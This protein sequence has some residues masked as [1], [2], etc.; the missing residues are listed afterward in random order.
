[1]KNDYIDTVGHDILSWTVRH[2]R[3]AGLEVDEQSATP[4]SASDRVAPR[5]T[6]NPIQRRRWLRE[7]VLNRSPL[8]TRAFAY[9]FYRYVIR[10]GFLDGK[11]G[12][13]FHFLQ[14][15]WYR[16][17]IDAVVYERSLARGAAPR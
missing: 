8:F 12:L 13:I 16:F 9:W 17:L 1:L 5:L 14:G 4:R 11:Q 2:A 15:C 3:W 10:L 6:G 7:R